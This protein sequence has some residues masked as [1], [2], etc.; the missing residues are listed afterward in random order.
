MALYSN[1]KNIASS[2]HE[3]MGNSP[4]AGYFERTTI[5]ISAIRSRRPTPIAIFIFIIFITNRILLNILN[6]IKDIY[7]FIV[8][9]IDYVTGRNLNAIGKD[10]P[11]L[12]TGSPGKTP[13]LNFV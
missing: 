6:D 3:E 7:P 1:V 13:F 4:G 5:T 12:Q 8:I 11:V 10:T 2:I 9:F